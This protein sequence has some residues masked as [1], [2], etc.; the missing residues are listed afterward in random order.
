MESDPPDWVGK[1]RNDPSGWISSQPVH[2]GWRHFGPFW[3]PGLPLA[4]IFGIASL[5][6]QGAIRYLWIVFMVIGVLILM[7]SVIDLLRSRRRY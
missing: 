6:S 7:I 1:Q 3:F 2:L 5:F 4:V